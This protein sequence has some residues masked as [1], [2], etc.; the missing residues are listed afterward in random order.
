MAY[1]RRFFD[2]LADGREVQEYTDVFDFAD[3]NG[4][5]VLMGPK[6]ELKFRKLV[7]RMPPEYALRWRR[8]LSGDALGMEFGAGM[9]EAE[10]IVREE[11]A[12]RQRS[13]GFLVIGITC[14]VLVVVLALVLRP[15]DPEP[16][17]GRIFFEAP[18]E[19]PAEI[20]A[21]EGGA[22][23]VNR[24]LL[25]PLEQI[26]AVRAGTGEVTQR[27]SA[28]ADPALLPHATATLSATLFR[29]GD[30]GYVVIAGP[31]GFA[32]SACLQISAVTP[33]L[34][35]FDTARFESAPGACPAGVV[36]RAATPACAGE[37]AIMLGLELPTEEFDLEE[38][39][40]GAV[41]AVSVLSIGKA[42]GFDLMS[43]RGRIAVAGG[44][45]ATVPSFGGKKGDVITFDMSPKDAP[46]P[47]LGKCTLS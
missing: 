14:L 45:T 37:T 38:G 6:E 20:V 47:V 3:R 17:V 18:K 15:G 22:P 5:L 21:F 4:L 34:R 24:E 26:V 13:L 33:T 23:E 29:L 35:P 2:I 39:G 11:K 42:Q 27:V 25:V 44:K 41:G 10:R 46:A 31:A 7:D 32:K 30:R 43:I 16:P 36:G 1:A 28:E 9:S 40:R 19:G 12:G 8:I